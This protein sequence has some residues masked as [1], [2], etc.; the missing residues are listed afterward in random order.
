[1]FENFG[2]AHALFLVPTI[3]H[4]GVGCVKNPG[5]LVRV[6]AYSMEL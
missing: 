2:N 6:T 4:G 3:W 1:M 5:S